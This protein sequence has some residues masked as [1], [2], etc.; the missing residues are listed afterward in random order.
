VIAFI[1]GKMRILNQK[2]KLGFHRYSPLGGLPEESMED[3]IRL[4][5]L[6]FKHVAGVDRRFVEKAFS[7]PSD[8]MWYPFIDE[9]IEAGVITHMVDGSEIIDLR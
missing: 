8:D 3:Q 1:A 2:A 6:Y 4:D 5:K 9:L 7:T